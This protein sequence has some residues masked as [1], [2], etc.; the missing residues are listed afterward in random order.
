MQESHTERPA[1]STE[2]VIQPPWREGEP[3]AAVDIGRVV[4]VLAHA[5]EVF[6]DRFKVMR[7]LRTPIP[8][9]GDETPQDMLARAGGIEQVDQVLG[10]IE[11]GVW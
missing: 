6:G 11:H 7:W 8:A 9:L 10:R 4:D 1:A 3:T 2:P 5:L